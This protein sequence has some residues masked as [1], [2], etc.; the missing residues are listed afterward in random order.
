MAT[1]LQRNGA[2]GW[3]LMSTRSL[4]NRIHM[5]SDAVDT[6]KRIADIDS[7]AFCGS[8][9]SAAA[10]HLAMKHDLGLIY[11]R[12]K[13]EH[14][15]GWSVEINEPCGRYIIVDDFISSGRTI[16]WIVSQINERVTSFSRIDNQKYKCEL[17]GV[18]LYDSEIAVRE[19][20]KLVPDQ[21]VIVAGAAYTTEDLER[22]YVSW[23][24]D[25]KKKK[26]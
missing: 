8:S 10:F 11:V 6:F 12:K 26:R 4:S 25:R 17:H 21:S 19:D 22:E 23:A 1:K 20:Y 18:V 7:I 3:A 13:D 16:Q 2:Y 9:G 5:I 15:H 14:S 24:V